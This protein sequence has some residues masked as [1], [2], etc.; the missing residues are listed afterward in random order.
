[1]L[2]DAFAKGAKESG[3][4]VSKIRVSD[5]KIGYYAACYACKKIGRCIIKDDVA[6][7]IIV[8]A[9]QS[10]AELS[11]E[12]NRLLPGQSLIRG[13]DETVARVELSI[14]V[15]IEA[16]YECEDGTMWNV[17]H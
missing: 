4:K 15:R 14:V 13:I 17:E 9:G 16:Y 2:C 11:E 3:D 8:C 5:K 6:A 7:K 12:V 1:M 10:S